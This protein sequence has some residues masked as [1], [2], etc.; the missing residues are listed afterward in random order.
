MR[1]FIIST[2][3][4]ADLPENFITDHH[5]CVIPHY[6]SIDDKVYGEEE[7]VSIETFYNAMRSKK[8][9]A[10]MASNPAVIKERFA[11]HAEAGKDILHIS[12]S[13]ELSAGYSNIVMMATEIMEE[14][15]ECTIK[16]VD[17]KS[18]SAGEMMMIIKALECL[19]DGKSLAETAAVVEALVPHLCLQFVVDDLDYL[20][21]GG[22]LSKT[23]AILGSIVAVKPILYVDEKGKL[24]AL[25]KVRGRKKSIAALADNMEK[26]LGTFRDKQITVGIIHGDCEADALYL[27]EIIHSRFGYDDFIIR[28]IGPSIGAH[29]GPGALGITYLGEYR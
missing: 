22:R 10:T 13:S 18:A 21:R 9:V 4:N 25:D 12:F 26:R 23:S 8:K 2:E 27:K 19:G 5:I 15:P 14:Y 29:S 16:V 24:A 20:Y 11:V 6:Y 28:P 3:S 7:E 1:E 17:T